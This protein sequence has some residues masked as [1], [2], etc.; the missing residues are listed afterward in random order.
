MTKCNNLNI[1]DSFG[2]KTCDLFSEP[3]EQVTDLGPKA[4]I[5]DYITAW[6]TSFKNHTQ[7]IGHTIQPILKEEGL[8]LKSQIS[9]SKAVQVAKKLSD[10]IRNTFVGFHRQHSNEVDAKISQ[11]PHSRKYKFEATQDA[12]YAIH[13]NKGSKQLVYQLLAQC[14]AYHLRNQTKIEIPLNGKLISYDIEKIPLFLNSV[15]FGLTSLQSPPILL[16][17]GTITKVLRNG[18]AESLVADFDPLGPGYTFFRLNKTIPEWLAKN[19]TVNKAIVIGHSLGGAYAKHTTAYYP[20]YIE[21]TYTFNSPGVGLPTAQKYSEIK[22]GSPPILNIYTY[23]DIIPKLSHKRIGVDLAVMLPNGEE[24]KKLSY[25]DKHRIPTFATESLIFNHPIQ[26]MVPSLILTLA[27]P[28]IFS[29][30]CLYLAL[31][32]IIGR[33]YSECAQ[34]IQNGFRRLPTQCQVMDG[35]KGILGQQALASV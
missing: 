31:R 10:T 3:P 9:H 27:L 34:K 33:M 13:H 32:T 26:M 7:F 21:E 18:A 29:I 22:N 1:S 20:E 12:L 30:G 17:R 15:A 2:I 14:V 19:T 8:N 11:I 5:G 35:V 4:K 25:L 6:G 16:F 23:G 28:V 24:H